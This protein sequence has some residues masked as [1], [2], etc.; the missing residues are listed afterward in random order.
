MEKLNYDKQKNEYEKCLS[1]I[2]N[3]LNKPKNEIKYMSH[4][5]GSYNNDT[6]AILKDLGIE[7]GFKNIMT[8]ELE[9]GMKKINNTNL[10]VARIN[11]ALV[12]KMMN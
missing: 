12:M 3:I 1:L 6:L 7:L 5:C 10:E 11:H 9:K 2:S 4:P 8:I